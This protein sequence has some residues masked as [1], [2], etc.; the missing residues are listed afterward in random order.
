MFVL[1]KH[2]L[3]LGMFLCLISCANVSTQSGKT[4]DISKSFVTQ[5]E[6]GKIEEAFEMLKAH[7]PMSNIEV[8]NLKA[9]TIQ[10]RKVVVTRY[11]EPQAVEFVRSE[12]VGKSLVRH[13]FLEKFD[14]HALKWELSFYKNKDK[15]VISTVYWDDDISSLFLG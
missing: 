14:N 10:Q 6:Q 2:V 8:D 3:I 13:T 5:V 4:L 7:W 11:G 9:H 1:L 12:L 15:W